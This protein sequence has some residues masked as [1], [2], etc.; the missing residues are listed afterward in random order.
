MRKTINIFYLILLARI[1]TS[2]TTPDYCECKK[3]SSDAIIA[4]SGIPR[5]VD[6]DELIKCGEKVKN[7]IELK[8]PS[9]KISI[10]YIQQVSYEMCNFGFY[11]GKGSDS[12]KYY[13]GEGQ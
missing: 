4:S 12:K 5:S 3:I 2:C 9:D 13:K 1:I 10:N 8:I 7:D 11:E 6:L